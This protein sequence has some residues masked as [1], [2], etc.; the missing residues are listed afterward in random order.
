MNN[1]RQI[2]R[3]DN[4]IAKEIKKEMAKIE[5]LPPP[6]AW[7]KISSQL[8]LAGSASKN[9]KEPVPWYRSLGFAA[10]VLFI[11]G[12]GS[13]IFFSQVLT[14]EDPLT[15]SYSAVDMLQLNEEPEAHDPDAGT[16]SESFDTEMENGITGLTDDFDGETRGD[17]PE[18]LP[19]R[20]HI[21]SPIPGI[22]D[23]L[24][25]FLL[26]EVEESVGVASASFFLYTM[27]DK[28][29]WL[30]LSE[31]NPGTFGDFPGL[32][33]RY[34]P[35]KYLE[36]IDE[37][38]TRSIVR[39]NRENHIMVWM[40]GNDYYLLWSRTDNVARRDLMELRS[41]WPMY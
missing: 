2:E 38:T 31:F 22:P 41:N 35:E 13:S 7:D 28:E 10:S 40:Y 18:R 17:T 15:S 21:N 20:P 27:E 16:F 11:L 9:K 6:Y 1:T 19:E 29:V 32:E 36:G 8:F 34:I 33:D 25:G 24:N 14:P 39:D 4:L 26:R 23:S 5:D 3:E 12:V 30:V 37:K